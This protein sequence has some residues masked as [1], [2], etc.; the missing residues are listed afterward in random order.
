MRN[1]KVKALRKQMK[2]MGMDPNHR[3]YETKPKSE[4]LKPITV[5]AKVVGTFTT[6]TTQLNRKC[7][8]AK[9]QFFKAL[10]KE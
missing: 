4:R 2:L 9:F 7:G 1:S 5:N 3:V 10:W 8:R 6:S